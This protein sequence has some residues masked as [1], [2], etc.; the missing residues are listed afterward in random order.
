MR[1]EPGLGLVA[2]PD[3]LREGFVA[4][5]DLGHF[6]FDRGEILRRERLRAIE[7]VIKAVLDHRPDRDLRA[8]K[9][10]LHRLGEHMR[11]IMADEFER[12]WIVAG[13]EFDFGVAASADR[14][15]RARLPS[16]AIATVRLASDGE[17]LLA[18]VEPA[19]A[20]LERRAMRRPEKLRKSWSSPCCSL[21]DT[22]RRKL[23]W[24]RPPASPWTIP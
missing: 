1:L 16:S 9:E 10:R 6:L 21:A 23:L 24:A 5:D 8:G 19:D 12:S 3:F 14:R 20:G 7:I 17:M 15:G 18:I 13:D 22:N 11:G 4:G 2:R